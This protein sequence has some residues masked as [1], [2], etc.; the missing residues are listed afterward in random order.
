M[1]EA[2]TLRNRAPKVGSWI[3]KLAVAVV[4]NESKQFGD[5]LQIKNVALEVLKQARNNPG[6]YC[7]NLNDFPL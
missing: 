1:P 3:F 2:R 5:P 7:A 6:H 4:T